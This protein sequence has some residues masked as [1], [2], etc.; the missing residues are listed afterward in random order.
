[1]LLRKSYIFLFL[2]CFLAFPIVARGGMVGSPAPDFTLPSIDRNSVS[3]DSLRGKVVFIDFWAS[4]CPPCKKEFPELNRLLKNLNDPD[5]VVVAI[6]VDK[7]RSHATDF[8]ATIRGG[9]SD[10]LHVV[11]DPEARVIPSY[12]ALAMPTSFI[13]DRTGIVR[14]IHFGFDE[15]DPER[16]VGEVKGLLSEGA[17]K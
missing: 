5:F 6:N 2:L 3:L 15:S 8:L 13:V 1:M 12:N 10:R 11:L 17:A 9:L 7:K 16:W 4:W 14:Y